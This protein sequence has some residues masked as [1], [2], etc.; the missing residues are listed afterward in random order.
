MQILFWIG[1]RIW[2]LIIRKQTILRVSSSPRDTRG[3]KGWNLEETAAE[4]YPGEGE[5]QISMECVLFVHHC[6]I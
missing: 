3:G 4:T 2:I 5:L 1:Q 6:Y